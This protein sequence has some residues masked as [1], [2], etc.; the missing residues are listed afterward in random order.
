MI[1]QLRRFASE[2]T[3]V[4]LV[5]T[6][7]IPGGQAMIEGFQGTWAELTTLLNVCVFGYWRFAF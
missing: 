3:R 2:I 4:A 7:D 5:G 6:E 1:T